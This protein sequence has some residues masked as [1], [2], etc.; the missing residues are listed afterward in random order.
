MEELQGVFKEMAEAWPHPIVLR[1]NR[2]LREFSFGY[3]RSK[4]TMA[5]HDSAGRGPKS[6]MVGVRRAYRK[7]DLALW[8]QNRTKMLNEQ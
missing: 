1:D 4:G 6:L 2:D 5:N 3:I 8:L 7:E